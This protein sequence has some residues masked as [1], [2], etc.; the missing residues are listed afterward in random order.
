MKKSDH[1]YMIADTKKIP[2]MGNN[3]YTVRKIRGT[4]L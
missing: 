2:D 3:Q 4:G 1:A